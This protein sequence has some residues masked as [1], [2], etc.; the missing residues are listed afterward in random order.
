MNRIP[1]PKAQTAHGD[2]DRPRGLARTCGGGDGHSVQPTCIA[3]CPT[4][5]SA[6]CQQSDTVLTELSVMEDGDWALARGGHEELRLR[7][8]EEARTRALQLE[9]TMRWWSDCTA[10]WREKWA[11]V[12]AERNRAREEARALRERLEGATAELA[13]ARRE[14]RGVSADSARTLR[15]ETERRGAGE[16]GDEEDARDRKDVDDEDDEE[17]ERQQEDLNADDDDDREAGD[18]EREPGDVNRAGKEVERMSSPEQEPVRDTEPGKRPVALPSSK[19]TMLIEEAPGGGGGGGGTGSPAEPREKRR[20]AGNYR[21]RAGPAGRCQEAAVASAVE[22]ELARATVLRLR[23]DESLK[24]L[25]KEREDK[26]E[27]TK[28]IEKLEAEVLQWRLKNEELN[29]SKQ[30]A[31]KQLALLREAHEAELGRMTEDLE[32]QVGAHSSM[33]KK[34]SDMRAELERL[35][36]EN[37]A[38]WGKRER[39]DTEKL[40]LERDNKKLRLQLDDLEE[41][42][43]KRS[44]QTAS[45]SDADLRSVQAQLYEKNK[46]LC[47]L[48]HAYGKQRKAQADVA[49]ELAHAQRRAEQ[50]EAEVKKLRQRV[51]ELKREA[52]RAEDELDESQNQVR[53]LQ[54]SLDEQVETSE[55]LQVQLEHLQTRLRRQQTDSLFGKKR[56]GGRYE[57]SEGGAAGSEE[58]DGSSS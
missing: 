39:L 2:A 32:D 16:E 48:R 46:E 41:Q 45:A 11:K 38:E 23:L 35:Q 51:D 6:A 10:S 12:R 37:A 26:S 36:A 53:R 42:L 33:D 25:L 5:R 17:G 27:L 57:P 52:A 40:A 29:K 18:A 4:T 15:A 13:E 44:K 8:L 28:T 43:S 21:R 7:E 49:A 34:L 3:I 9:K 22:E 56:S 1:S 24:T 20:D 47:D 50:S 30:E 58:D 14:R 31:L 55:N 54:R 19:D